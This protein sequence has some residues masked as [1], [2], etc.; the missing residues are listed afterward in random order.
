MQVWSTI[1]LQLLHKT[2]V[3]GLD[4][5]PPAD[6]GA[7]VFVANHQSFLDIY[8]LYRLGRPFR[9]VSKS[10]NFK[11]PFIGGMMKLNDY[12]PLERSTPMSQVV[13]LLHETLIHYIT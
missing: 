5:I 7:V 4:N 3:E 8:P 10:D 2:V 1:S 6:A 13:C 11:V 9:I 12:I